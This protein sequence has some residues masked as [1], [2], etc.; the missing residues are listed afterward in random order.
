MLFFY[1]ALCVDAQKYPC[2]LKKAWPGF[3]AWCS[4]CVCSGP[5]YRG[6]T[7]PPSQLVLP[8][9]KKR[10]LQLHTIHP[11]GPWPDVWLPQPHGPKRPLPLRQHTQHLHVWKWQSGMTESWAELRLLLFFFFSPSANPLQYLVTWAAWPK[12]FLQTPFH[13]SLR[14]FSHSSSRQHPLFP[15]MAVFSDSATRG[16]YSIKNL[17]Q[18]CSHLRDSNSD[19]WNILT[20]PT[21]VFEL[22]PFLIVALIAFSFVGCLK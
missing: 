19:Y 13:M 10:L 12:C 14:S 20:P 16:H 2:I 21:A 4:L 7:G 9:F 1:H 11:P 15:D 18:S 5:V 8:L 3:W 6:Q 22:I 17:R